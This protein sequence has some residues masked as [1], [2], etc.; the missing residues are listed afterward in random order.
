MDRRAWQAIVHRVTQSWTPLKQLSTQVCTVLIVVQGLS[1]RSWGL[2]SLTRDRIWT[3]CFGN[4]ESYLLDCQ[5]S[6]LLLLLL[7]SRFSHVR[8]CATP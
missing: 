6:P 8:L 3:P 5:G 7:L 4:M 2:S 1:Y